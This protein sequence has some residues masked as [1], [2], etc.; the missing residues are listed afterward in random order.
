MEALALTNLPDNYYIL[1][2]FLQSKLSNQI[3]KKYKQAQIKN[4]S[5]FNSDVFHMS[6]AGIDLYVPDSHD[7]KNG[8]RSN[9]VNMCI[10]TSMLFVSNNKSIPCSYYLYMRSSTGSK[11]PLRLS[12]Q[13]GIMDTGY[14]G[15]VIAC[16]DNID[17]SNGN[18]NDYYSVSQGDR[19]VQ[20]CSPNITYPIVLNIVNDIEELDFNQSFV[21]VR[22][23][24]GFGSTGR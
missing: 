22:G 19:L 18:D 14:R 6:D 4:N 7:I 13:V 17:D 10:N 11:T 21:N 15:D 12:N 3:V 8:S 2:I 9:K 20:I 24:G 5:F 1:N 16:F 23:G